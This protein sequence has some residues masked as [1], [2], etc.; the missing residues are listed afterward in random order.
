MVDEALVGSVWGAGPGDT[1]N[2]QM[3]ASLMV[4]VGSEERAGWL[5][6]WAFS[7]RA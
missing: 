7:A 3:L 6:S 4:L 2:P 1:W 5:T